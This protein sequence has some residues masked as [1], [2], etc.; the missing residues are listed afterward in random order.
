M[1]IPVRFLPDGH[2]KSIS[3]FLNRFMISASEFV[4]ERGMHSLFVKNGR[5]N[6]IFL[7]YKDLFFK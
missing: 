5:M 7:F 3:F 2:K 4:A 6:F 1:L